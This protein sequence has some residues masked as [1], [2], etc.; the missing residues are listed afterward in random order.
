MAKESGL[1]YAVAVDD[2]GGTA[3]TIS[4]DIS[5]FTLS[6]SR[7]VLNFTGIDAS[8]L[9]RGLSHADASLTFTGNFDDGANLAHDVFKTVPSSDVARLVTLS[10]SGQLLDNSNSDGGITCVFSSYDLNRG[11]DGGLTWSAPGVLSDGYVPTWTTP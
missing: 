2:S 3:R 6:L 1:G 11:S 5:D 10:H 9:E 7:G 8:A 4:T